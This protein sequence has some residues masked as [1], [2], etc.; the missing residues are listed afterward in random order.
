M[1]LN[2]QQ[3]VG[4]ITISYS[5]LARSFKGF[6]HSVSLEIF[7]QLLGHI[8]QHQPKPLHKELYIIDSTPFSLSQLAYRWSQFRPTQSGIKVH[9]IL[10]YME[11]GDV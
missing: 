8:E 4:L 10:Q 9:M 2:L 1:N 11:K 5:Q 7:F 3:K 6:P